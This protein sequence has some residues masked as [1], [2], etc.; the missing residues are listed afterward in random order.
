VK[1]G[2]QVILIRNESLFQQVKSNSIQNLKYSFSD[3]FNATLIEQMEDNQNIFM[4]IL[5]IGDL[6]MRLGIGCSRKFTI[7]LQRNPKP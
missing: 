4:K 3:I 6:V 7:A 1:L 5:T 2:R